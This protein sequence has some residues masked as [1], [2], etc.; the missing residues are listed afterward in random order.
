MMQ[1]DAE[2][3]NS[4]IASLQHSLQDALAAREEMCTK[5]HACRLNSCN[6]LPMSVASQN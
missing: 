6:C 5:V 4:K 3:A 1:A 2:Q